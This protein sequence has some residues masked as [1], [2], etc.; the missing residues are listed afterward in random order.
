MTTF[1]KFERKGAKLLL[2]I[3]THNKLPV[4]FIEELNFNELLVATSLGPERRQL[5]TN[6]YG[7]TFQKTCV[8]KVKSVYITILT[9]LEVVTHRNIQ[10]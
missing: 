1:K 3:L 4:L 9:G 10:S 8:Q 6:Q 5:H 2:E 7:I